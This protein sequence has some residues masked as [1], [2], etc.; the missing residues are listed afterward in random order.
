MTTIAEL[1]AVMND[2]G[3]GRGRAYLEQ[4]AQRKT[5]KTKAIAK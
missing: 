3:F 1:Q 4:K 5:L 2:P